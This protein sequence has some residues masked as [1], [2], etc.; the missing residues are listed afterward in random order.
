MPCP[1]T[2]LSDYWGPGDRN[3]AKPMDF[4]LPAIGEGVYEAE[5]VRWLVKPG[6]AFVPGQ[7]L[8]EVLTDKATMEVPAPFAGTVAALKA[9]PGQMVKVGQPLLEYSGNGERAASAAPPAKATAAPNA[10]QANGSAVVETPA[11]VKAA[12]S[13]RHMARKLGVDLAS[14]TGSGPEGRILMEDLSRQGRPPVREAPPTKEARP[15]HGQPGT[16][17]KLAGLRR[18]IAEHMVHA[19]RTIPHYSYVDE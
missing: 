16:R 8:A 7:S 10:S 12:P 9:E 2:P 19:K 5:L 18:R 13:V 14:V 3:G 17:V 11:S 15:D 4:P 6:D 1:L